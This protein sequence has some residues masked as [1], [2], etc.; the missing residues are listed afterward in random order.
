MKRFFDV[1]L[2]PRLTF[3]PIL[4]SLLLAFAYKISYLDSYPHYSKIPLATR[5]F[6]HHTRSRDQGLSTPNSLDLGSAFGVARVGP[7]RARG[8]GGVGGIGSE[9]VVE[10]GGLP[11]PLWVLLL[12]LELIFSDDLC[13]NVSCWMQKNHHLT[14]VG[15]A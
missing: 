6:S 7:S 1:S 11:V 10:V 12:S 2:N 9:E 8:T 13:E 5:L 15:L 4:P 3:W 14:F